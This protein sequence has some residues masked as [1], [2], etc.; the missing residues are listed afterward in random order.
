MMPV[1]NCLYLF[2]LYEMLFVVFF[3]QV[4]RTLFFC[5]LFRGI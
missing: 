2:V 3:F 5:V 1:C 4:D